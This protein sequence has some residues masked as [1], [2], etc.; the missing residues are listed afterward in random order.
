M[1]NTT[2]AQAQHPQL[3]A[4]KIERA[5][6]AIKACIV[7]SEV[8]AMLTKT[9][10]L[11][12]AT[13]KVISIPGGHLTK[14]TAKNITFGSMKE[15]AEF[16][17]NAALN[18]ALIAAQHIG[19]AEE[20]PIYSRAEYERQGQ[21]KGAV[22]RTK[23]YF[24]RGYREHGFLSLDCDKDGLSFDEFYQA[25][26]SVIP[27]DKT[28]WAYGPSSGSHLAN[29]GKLLPGA[30]KKGHRLLVVIDDAA[31]TKEAGQTLFYKLWLKDYCQFE[32]GKAGQ[33]LERGIIDTAMFGDVC[34]LDFIGGSHCIPPLT[35]QRPPV[36]YNEGEP[37]S[38]SEYLDGLTDDEEEALESSKR[39]QRQRLKGEIEAKRDTYCDEK[40]REN[41]K[42]KGIVN[43]SIDEIE[44]AK[45]NVKKALESGY[46]TADF[47]ITLAKDKRQITI[48]EV[49]AEPEKYDGA[50]TLDPIEPEYHNYSAKGILY[51]N[52]GE[53]NLY[54]Q[55]HGGK[56][57]KLY[58]QSRL[59]QHSRGRTNRTTDET[60]ALLKA[61]P[62]FFDMGGQLVRVLNGQV[63][64]LC[65]AS[66]SYALGSVAQY[67]QETTDKKGKVTREDIDPPPQVVKQLLGMGAQRGLKP[68]QAV[69]TAPTITADNHI[70]YKRGYD[71]R[72]QL[73]LD[74][75]TDLPKPKTVPTREDL[76]NSYRSLMDIID[77]FKL[78]NDIDRSVV[79]SAFLTAVVRPGIDKAPIYA[80][81]AP[82]KGS[83]KTYLA[84][85]IGALALGYLPAMTP[86]SKAGDGEIKKTL[87]PK[88][89]QGERA[90]IFDNILGDFN[91]VSLA[92]FITSTVYTDRILGSSQTISLPNKSIVL[93]TGNNL[94][95]AGDLPRRCVSARIDT[96][97]ENPIKAKH[98]L[99]KL[100]GVKPDRYIL[101]NRQ[102]LVMDC[103]T[104]VRGFLVSND[105]I[106]Q[107]GLGAEITNTFEQWGK[108]ARQPIRHLAQLGIDSSLRDVQESTD[109]NI[110]S[111]P[112]KERT[113]LLVDYLWRL[114]GSKP[115]TT[116]DVMNAAFDWLGVPADNVGGDL[117][118]LL[119]EFMHNGKK[120]NTI[121]VGKVLAFRVDNIVDGKCIK[122]IETPGRRAN[123]WKIEAVE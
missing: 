23:D 19:E 107:Q 52:K 56:N 51:L 92:T 22:T 116:K 89:M 95:L 31:R 61:L 91:S 42:K 6:L 93:L 100:G 32:T 53:P 81:D 3:D 12:P 118:E 16:W 96:G 105:S 71:A 94:S 115:F 79:L 90:I 68:L 5:L 14:G 48:G 103:I 119:R 34:R 122:L 88:L 99:S 39:A 64:P 54:S 110:A 17:D 66:L 35:Q 36:I 55:A 29:D 40:G 11:D 43:P 41:L 7:T 83:G 26:N 21:P 109:K 25:I 72:S 24:E 112:H 86:T 69:I 121:S 28:A 47:V 27:L 106:F 104:I 101:Q 8:P 4:Q 111:D 85:C 117:A 33:L 62:D 49:L 13:G 1:E 77:T 9:R 37:L 123:L 87:L 74:I 113:A 108:L 114:F 75:D 46:L 58:K 44:Q 120:P 78:K 76:T 67:Y 84:E 65:E 59:I 45:E 15:V 97:E 80:L 63:I 38:V 18:Q 82:T 57:Y 10:K 70:V 102:R 60:K 98:D 73:Y 20:V 50:A 2:K 30:D